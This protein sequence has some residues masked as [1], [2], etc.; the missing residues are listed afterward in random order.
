[1]KEKKNIIVSLMIGGGLAAA[2]A[3]FLYLSGYEQWQVTQSSVPAMGFN[4]IA[5]TF[6]G[7]LN[8]IGTIFSSY[9]IQHIT[10][11]GAYLDKMIYPSQVSDLISAIII[12]LCG[13]MMFFRLFL[14]SRAGKRSDKAAAKAAAAA[15]AAT[16]ESPGDAVDAAQAA[17]GEAEEA[18]ETA[19]EE[20]EVVAE[21]AAEQVLDNTEEGGNA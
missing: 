14:A 6:L 7:A 13:F 18:V 15:N 3:A 16:G 5:A 20:A 21:E 12:Y 19:A 10:S 4:G 8:P 17:A 11:G 9:F 2:G 1:M